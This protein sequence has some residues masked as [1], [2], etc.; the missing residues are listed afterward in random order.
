MV[1]LRVVVAESLN[2]R[3]LVLMIVSE[4]LMVEILPERFTEPPGSDVK[5]T[6][7]LPKVM[8]VGPVVF[9]LLRMTV[10]AASKDFV[11]A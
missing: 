8:F 4:P 3:V 10:L 1:K 5:F 11:P 9:E 2:S 6:V 7:K